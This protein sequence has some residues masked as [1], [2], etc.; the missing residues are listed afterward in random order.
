[1]TPVRA[2]LFIIL[3]SVIY[4]FGDPISKYAFEIVPVYSALVIRYGI[5]IAVLFLF[6]GERII[7]DLKGSKIKP[8]IL[9]SISIGIAYVVGN[10]AI[11]LTE[12][13][14]VAFLR[15]LAIVFTPVLAFLCYGIS[16]SWKQIP[17]LL[18]MLVGLYLLCGVADN[19]I[20]GVGA[21]EILAMISALTLAA[22][23][24]FGKNALE[25]TT[26]LGL[27]TVQ[28]VV[29]GI[30]TLF[31]TFLI[32]GKIDFSTVDG[33]SLAILVYIGIACTIGGYLLQ[34]AALGVISARTIALLQCSCPVITALFSFILLGEVL[35]FNGMLGCVIILICLLVQNVIKE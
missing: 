11:S 5:A 33:L 2:I 9:P 21:G 32:D 4:G 17:V 27:T 13:T 25:S 35:S 20:S 19:G 24:V 15:S 10:V 7:R 1:M 23:L 34:N 3:Q 29:T 16:C 30:I 12:A 28:T 6:A 8:L 18:L 31:A 14:T 26:P 22:S